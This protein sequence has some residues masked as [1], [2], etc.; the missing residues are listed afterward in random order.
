MRKNIY[1]H[2]ETIIYTY[3]FTFYC[4]CLKN[5]ETSLNNETSYNEAAAQ[6]VIGVYL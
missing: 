3:F 2:K 5:H 6:F 1:K 4:V